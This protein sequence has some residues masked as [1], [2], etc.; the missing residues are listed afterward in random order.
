MNRDV[1]EFYS[2]LANYNAVFQPLA[3]LASENI[4]V[5]NTF[6]NKFIFVTGNSSK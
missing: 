3:N 2:F 1:F 5:E 6:P 4:K